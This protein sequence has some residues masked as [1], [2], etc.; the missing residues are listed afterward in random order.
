M[1]ENVLKMM[2]AP[3]NSAIPAK[4]SRK[5]LM[6]V[7]KPSRP[8][9][10]NGSAAIAVCTFVGVPASA[11]ATAARTAAARRPARPATE[12]ESTSPRLS[13]SA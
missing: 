5:N 3:T 9:K 2:N 10:S 1:I 4:A 13:K 12:I 7:T 8:L 11:P 6:N